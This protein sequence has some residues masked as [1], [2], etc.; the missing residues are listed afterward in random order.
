MP[1][2]IESTH[3]LLE[4]KLVV[5]QRP[6]SDVWQCRYKV[7]DKWVVVTTK[8][9]DLSKAKERAHRLMIEG[10]IRKEANLPVVTKYFKDIARL[11][12]QRMVDEAELGSVPV[13]Y[14]DYARII[15]E[16]LVPFFGKKAIT[17]L[18]QTDLSEFATWREVQM[19]K[20]PAYSTVRSHNVTLNRVFDEAVKRGFVTHTHLPKLE[21]KGK[22]AE[23][24]PTFTVSEINALLANFDHWISL[25]R[26]EK[27]RQQRQLMFDY[28]TVL[29]DTGARPGKELLNVQWK[30]IELK[31]AHKTQALRTVDEEGRVTESENIGF[32]EEH[33]E[34]EKN[35]VI[36]YD[37]FI[38]VD[39]K[40][41]GRYVLGKEQTYKTLRK[42]AQR[43][44]E[45]ADPKSL[46]DKKDQR[47]VFRTPNGEEAS[48]FNHLFE[49]YLRDHNLLLDSTTGRKRVFYS[50]RSTYT[51]YM[52]DLD[53]ASTRDL[54]H[55]L[56]NSPTM[57][58]KHY[59]RSNT[60]QTAKNLA[61]KETRN[62]F[63]N[64]DQTN[65]I[66][67]PVIKAS[68]KVLKV[69]ESGKK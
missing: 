58:H 34:V 56:G 28:V 55:Q 44:F 61:G 48:S 10:E 33:H 14:S 6:N 53:Q 22:P 51:T 63:F 21:T 60:R 38:Y 36:D 12:K 52:L 32:D 39:G 24:Y 65:E 27:S 15:D 45:G 1:K 30:H 2:K 17:S 47:Y 42:I 68:A 43:N 69:K 13:S 57:I 5:Y 8:E 54:S 40:T 29:L 16:Y 62:A 20:V 67:A 35:W 25:A 23:R 46:V 49:R 66:Y 9:R 41:G 4:R 7:G 11:A 19:K 50:L 37:V 18:T 26:N 3:V 31:L 64:F 59:D